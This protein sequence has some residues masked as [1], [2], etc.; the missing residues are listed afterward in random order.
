MKRETII[1]ILA[2]RIKENA[3]ANIMSTKYA[4]LYSEQD[5]Q[6]II[7]AFEKAR[8]ESIKKIC[9]GS[10]DIPNIEIDGIFNSEEMRIYLADEL[11]PYF[12]EIMEFADDIK[13]L[14]SHDFEEFKSVGIFQSLLKMTEFCDL[15]KKNIIKCEEIV[16]LNKDKE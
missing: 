9:N 16:N 4:E 5:V 1:K 8:D 14:I 6:N 3:G 11:H 13:T 7:D 15:I 2:H 10:T 12:L